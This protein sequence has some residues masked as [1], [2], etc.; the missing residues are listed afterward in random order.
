MAPMARMARMATGRG[1]TRRCAC[2]RPARTARG[3]DGHGSHPAPDCSIR[4]L[5]AARVSWSIASA[6][7]PT[8]PAVGCL[9]STPV[10]DK[11]P[12]PVYERDD[13]R[14]VERGVHI[15]L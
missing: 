2:T 7:Q 6:C 5:G 4:A 14:D 11:E 15:A 1:N 9:D 10:S 12:S 3:A 8:P 13:A